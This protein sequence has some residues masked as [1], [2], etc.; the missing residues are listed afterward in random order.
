MATVRVVSAIRQQLKPNK[1]FFLKQ[2]VT[3]SPGGS[4]VVPSQL[5]ATSASWVRAILL[6][7]FPK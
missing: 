2:S 4:A 6:P 1:T 3:L 5:T 7:L